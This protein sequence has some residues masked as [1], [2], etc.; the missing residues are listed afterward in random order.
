MFFYSVLNFRELFPF[1]VAASAELEGYSDRETL[2]KTVTFSECIKRSD[3]LVSLEI[4][5]NL[6]SRTN[7]LG[8]CSTT[9]YE[10]RFI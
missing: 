9:E 8:K 10:K 7:T 4:V 1:I 5:T 2:D 3:F 6:F